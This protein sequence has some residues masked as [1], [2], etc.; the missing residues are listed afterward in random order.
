MKERIAGRHVVSGY[1]DVSSLAGQSRADDVPRAR[2][3]L[4]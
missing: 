3:Q 2:R 1:P 4:G